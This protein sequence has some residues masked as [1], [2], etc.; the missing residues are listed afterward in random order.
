MNKRSLCCLLG[1]LQSLLTLAQP[2]NA[3]PKPGPGLQKVPLDSNMIV[4]FSGAWGTAAYST[5]HYFDSK[6]DPAHQHFQPDKTT[7][8]TIVGGERY[9]TLRRQ[10]LVGGN[11]QQRYRIREIWVCVAPYNRF[12]DTIDIVLGD[13]AKSASFIYGYTNATKPTIQAVN[14]GAE[15]TW[16]KIWEGD[17]TIQYFLTNFRYQKFTHPQGHYPVIMETNVTG[18]LFYGAPTGHGESTFNYAPEKVVADADTNRAIIRKLN[19]SNFYNLFPVADCDSFTIIRK[20]IQQLWRF[21]H[22]T[23]VL[24]PQQELTAAE[25]YDSVLLSRMPGRRIYYSMHGPTTRVF[26][27]KG[28]FWWKPVNDT[29]SDPRN[30][31]SYTTLGKNMYSLAYTYGNNK[32]AEGRLVKQRNGR[33]KALN[34]H[35]GVEPGNEYNSA[36]FPDYYLDPIGAGCMMLMCIDGWSN[37][38]GSTYGAK[39]ADPNYKLYLPATAG[40]DVQY[41]RALLKFLQYAYNTTHPPIDYIGFHSYPHRFK[42]GVGPTTEEMIG[43]YITFPSDKSYYQDEVNALK[44]MYREWN[45]YIPIT[46]NEYGADKSYLRTKTANG[47]YDTTLYGIVQYD[48]YSPPQSLGIFSVSAKLMGAATSQAERA[49]YAFKDDHE[50]N[51]SMRY[52]SYNGSGYV[53]Y[54]W[55]KNWKVDSTIYWDN[56]YYD[57]GISRALFYYGKGRII[58]STS[59]GLFVVKFRHVTDPLKVVYAVWKDSSSTGKGIPVN[60]PVGNVQ[61]AQLMQGSFKNLTPVYRKITAI[62]GRIN[63]TATTLHKFFMVVEAPRRQ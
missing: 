20:G 47:Q 37:R 44:A 23:L 33:K 9:F 51:K 50:P 43:N 55:D 18:I 1:C 36:W 62:K 58:D 60:L 17:T 27:H 28:T 5:F 14:S 40:F 54:Y 32:T 48:K 21:Q 11:F 22:D 41:Q 29:L 56:Y 49:Q 31:L 16:Q 53:W 2:A 24:Q 4:D 3:I 12:P 13:S 6:A 8:N 34:L 30:P 15:H 42:K 59:G 57:Q 25:Y 7:G 35:W 46:V 52:T 38:W 19:G 10:R 61:S 63:T 39:N 26:G 45:G